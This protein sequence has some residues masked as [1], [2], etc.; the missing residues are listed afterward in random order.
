MH[1]ED[2]NDEVIKEPSSDEV[3]NSSETESTTN[4]NK[5]Q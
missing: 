2:D 5:E 3:D 4:D 1:E